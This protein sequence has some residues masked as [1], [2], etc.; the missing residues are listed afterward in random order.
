MKTIHSIEWQDTVF[1]K[2][3]F[4]PI[5]TRSYFPGMINSPMLMGLLIKAPLN[6]PLK[7]RLIFAGTANSF[8]VEVPRNELKINYKH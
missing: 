7:L 4:S 8:I 1:N 2:G 3:E 6:I 5:R